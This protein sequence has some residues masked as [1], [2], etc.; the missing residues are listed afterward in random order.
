MLEPGGEADL[1]LEAL[2]AKCRG[3]VGVQDLERDGPVVPQVVG[4]ID[5]GHPPA[6]ELA[7]EAVAVL[8]S[9][10]QGGQQS[11][12]GLWRS[13]RESVLDNR[14]APPNRGSFGHA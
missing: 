7:L 12:P 2:G 6:A 11:G 4:E 1:A 5:R 3:Q 8:E 13:R 14:P 9:L 10:R